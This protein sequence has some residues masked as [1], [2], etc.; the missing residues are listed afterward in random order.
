MGAS[1]ADK[2]VWWKPRW[3]YWPRLR[4]EFAEIANWKSWLRIT[5]VTILVIAPLILWG[6]VTYP[7]LQVP[8]PQILT[9]VPLV[10]GMLLLHFLLFSALPP[11]WELRPTKV[12]YAHGTHAFIARPEQ[13]IDIRI[14]DGP[15][16]VLRYQTK[17]A[18][19]R[20]REWK[21]GISSRTDLEKVQRLCELLMEERKRRVPV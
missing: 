15:T 2:V 10:A 13:I 19:G 20:E 17:G 11:R 8:W 3:S 1:S 5:A 9:A 18:R 6:L 12:H 7:G 14:V 21:A 16:I 4:R